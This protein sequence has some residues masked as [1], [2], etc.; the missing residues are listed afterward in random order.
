M[1]IIDLSAFDPGS[2]FEADVVIIGGGPAG[3]TIA[4]ELFDTALTVLVVES[5]ILHETPEHAALNEVESV[6]E[7]QSAAQRQKRAEFHGAN[8]LFWMPS[9]QS[10]GVRCRA[11]GGSTHAWAGKS[12]PFD[13]IDFSARPWAGCEGWPVGREALSPYIARAAKVLNLG[14]TCSDDEF[15]TLSKIR[16]PGPP[17]DKEVLAS[18][19]WQFARDRID[20]LDIMRFG[21]EFTR[22]HAS[23]VRV[24]L[25]ATVKQIELTPDG[26]RLHGLQIATIDNVCS[27]VRANTAVVAASGIENPRLLLASN[28]VQSKGIGNSH[29]LVGRF[30]MDHVGARV[31]AFDPKDV[32]PIIK[33]F[34]LY[35]L[36]HE[37]RAFMYMHGLSLSPSVQ[38]AEHLLNAALYFMP[39]R[40]PDDPLDALKRLLR[41][42]SYD[43]RADVLSVIHGAPL[44]AKGAGLRLLGSQAMPEIIKTAIIDAAIRYDPNLAAQEFQSRGLPHKLTGIS[45]DA[46]SEQRPNPDSRVTLSD[47]TDRLGVP[48]AR[49]DWRIC[50]QE[51]FTIMRLA[52][53]TS[54]A[55]SQAGLPQPEWAPWVS[56]ARPADGVLIDMAHTLGTTRMSTRPAEGVVDIDCRVHG[57]QGLYIAGGSVFPSSGHANPTLM[58]LAL[59]IRLADTLKSELL[60]RQIAA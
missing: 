18:Y 12:A 2:V 39:Q 45:I 46:I 33:R 17:I 53:L 19:F 21:R 15:W 40:A 42:K 50:D 41:G 59:A 52:Q 60:R 51:R 20:Q 26:T 16:P 29:D 48:L 34:G 24:L 47:R 56:Q 28:K 43:I 3:L 8:S 14:P 36:H 54:K 9:A 30:L 27:K 4:R 32:D 10:Y 31:A 55:F 11:L 5:G 7:P 49:I 37:G 1:E 35:S 58:I 38:K 57:V 25:N 22:Q 23:N 13:P 6:S 44:L